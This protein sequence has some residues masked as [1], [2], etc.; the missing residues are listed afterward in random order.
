MS[1]LILHHYTLSPFSEKARAMFGY[2]GLEWQSVTV[3]EMPP[4]PKLA[5]LASGYRKIPVAQI[6]AD[7]FCD[8]RTLSREIARLANKP[9]LVVENCS[10][11]VQ[12]F[13][14]EVDLQIFL[15]SIVTAGNFT[16][17]RRVLKESSLLDLGRLLLD[18]IKMGSKS[19][20]K[21]DSPREMR[22][23]VAGHLDHMETLLTGNFLFGDAP[24]AGDFSAYHSLWFRR[25]LA[26]RSI[27][28][29]HPKVEAWMNRMQAFGQG[30]RKDISADD[31]LEIARQATP[32]ALPEQV[33][34]AP[35]LGQAVRVAPS[36]YGR[37]P[38]FGELCYCD[39]RTLVVRRDDA[40]VG[41]IQVHF[42]RDG[43]VLSKAD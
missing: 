12:A 34:Q 39:D 43:F 8:T 31:A 27:A 19:K 13:V 33:E 36:D 20:V 25:D 26:G 5:P 4:R 32:R 11:E 15:A 41:Q 37:E 35:L 29:S 21:A 3:A 14:S 7:V 30:T 1:E 22:R 40:V 42:P 38:V 10:E 9:E 2:A 17:L 24:N 18:R 23:K 6:G 16:L 28:G